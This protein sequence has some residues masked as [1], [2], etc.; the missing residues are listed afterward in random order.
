MD[1]PDCFDRC[2]DLV[3]VC[4]IFESVPGLFFHCGALIARGK[5]PKGWFKST[6]VGE[7]LQA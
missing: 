5:C 6:V 2:S 7:W 4:S 3:E 1:L